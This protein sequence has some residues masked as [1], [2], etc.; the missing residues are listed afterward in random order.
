MIPS[1]KTW[2]VKFWTMQ[3]SRWYGR[4]LT[5]RVQ[6]INKR[7]ARMMANEVLGYPAIQSTKIT[8]GLINPNTK[9]GPRGIYRKSWL[10]PV[11]KEES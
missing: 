8:V 3:D 5:A 7:F 2:Q 9:H 1:V 10:G 6:T 11:K 4:V